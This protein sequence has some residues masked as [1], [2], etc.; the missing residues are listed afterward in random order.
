MKRYDD[1]RV[2]SRPESKFLW[3]EYWVDGKPYRESTGT[4][5]EKEAQRFLARRMAEQAAHQTG[6]TVFIGPQNTP[7]KHLLD[8]LLE[9]YRIR[10]RRSGPFVFHRTGQRIQTFRKAWAT[11]TQAAGM[12]G[13]RFHDF[14]RSPVRNLT[15]AGVP[16]TVTMSLTGHKT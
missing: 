10:G 5:D 13:R 1:G 11:A 14:R 8:L 7:L 2:S 12:T 9:D 3:V 16:D 15:C 6:F 4:A